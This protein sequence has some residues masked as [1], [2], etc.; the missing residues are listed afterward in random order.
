[1]LRD[2]QR[3]Y[4]DIKPSILNGYNFKIMMGTKTFNNYQMRSSFFNLATALLIALSFFLSETN[5]SAQ[6]LK[7]AYKNARDQER[8]SLKKD[9]KINPAVAY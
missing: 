4:W 8:A 2:G 5:V 1:M 3:K 7:D 9:S 6:T